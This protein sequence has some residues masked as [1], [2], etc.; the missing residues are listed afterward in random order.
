MFYYKYFSIYKY[1]LFL[2]FIRTMLYKQNPIDDVNNF[3]FNEK[4]N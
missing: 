2:L 1:N 4:N 3:I